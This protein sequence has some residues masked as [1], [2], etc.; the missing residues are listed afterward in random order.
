[1]G[2]LGIQI[3]Q[4]DYGLALGG[5]EEGKHGIEEESQHEGAWQPGRSHG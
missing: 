5:D 4:S 2:Y 3:L 1:M